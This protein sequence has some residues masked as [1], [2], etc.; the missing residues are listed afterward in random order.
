M[1]VVVVVVVV[2]AAAAAAAAAV[3]VALKMVMGGFTG[4]SVF[5]FP[6]RTHCER[7]VLV[8]CV[9]CL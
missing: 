7:N 8:R 9:T 1:V 5:S 3:V 6:N 4:C 2:V